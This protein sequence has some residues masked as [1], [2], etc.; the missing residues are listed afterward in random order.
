MLLISFIGYNRERKVKNVCLVLT[1]QSSASYRS[2]MG[3][4]VFRD[5][6]PKPGRYHGISCTHI[7]RQGGRLDERRRC[8]RVWP[9]AEY[10]TQRGCL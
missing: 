7:R 8:V 4:D 2:S 10:R 3:S 9:C 1:C 6:S 5:R